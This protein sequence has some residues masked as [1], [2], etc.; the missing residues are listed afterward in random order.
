[1]EPQSLSGRQKERP[2]DERLNRRVDIVFS[3]K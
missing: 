1:M 3:K 2:E